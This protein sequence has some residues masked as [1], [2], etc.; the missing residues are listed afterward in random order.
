MPHRFL[1]F[2]ILKRKTTTTS[3]NKQSKDIELESKIKTDNSI[4]SIDVQPDRSPHKGHHSTQENT[5]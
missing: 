5:G 3:K 2:W 4:F 1:R